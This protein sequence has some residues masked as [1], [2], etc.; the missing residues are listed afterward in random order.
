MAQSPPPPAVK[1][2]RNA[3]AIQLD[4]VNVNGEFT[5][6]LRARRTWRRYSSEPITRQELA[7]MLGLSVG[8]QK[9]IE[10]KGV[11]L[12]LKTSPSGGARHSVECY[13]V[14]RDVR[15][16]KSGIYHYAPDR[17]ALAKYSLPGTYERRRSAFTF[18]PIR[19]SAWRS[20][21]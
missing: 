15:G 8:V 11:S 19:T 5:H 12:P 20:G 18:L 1:R 16:L 13:V 7:T 4:P 17:H 3:A 6:V 2:Y 21:A 9:W 10:A 14:A